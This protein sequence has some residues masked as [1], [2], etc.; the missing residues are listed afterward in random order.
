MK[1]SIDEKTPPLIRKRQSEE[2]L[3]R[4]NENWENLRQRPQK[5]E[6]K[7]IVG[8]SNRGPPNGKQDRKPLK[9]REDPGMTRRC[10]VCG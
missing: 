5:W 6:L 8:P 9:K 7:E 10:N 2:N 4:E 1:R 3:G